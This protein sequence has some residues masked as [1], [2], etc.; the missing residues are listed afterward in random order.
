MKESISISFLSILIL[1]KKN[2]EKIII[3]LIFMLNFKNI[4]TIQNFKAIYNFNNEYY[5]IKAKSIDYYRYEKGNNFLVK[6]SEYSF[7][8]DQEI[9]T[10]EESEMISFGLFRDSGD[11]AKLIV[12]K[13]FVYA[14]LN[15]LCVCNTTL[16]EIE[17]FK[18]EIYGIK[19]ESQFHFCFYIIGIINSSKQFCLY[20]YKNP[21]YDC[22][23]TCVDYYCLNDIGSDNFSCELMKSSWNEDI[24]TCFYQ[25]IDSTQII[26]HNFNIN[27]NNYKISGVELPQDLGASYAECRCVLEIR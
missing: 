9:K 7:N 12:V 6:D 5:I 24:L 16:S 20:L 18:P 19:C 21:S 17:G 11:V 3:F 1:S 27:L 13:H 22:A 10:I 26:A 23:S 8:T 15:N 14:F 2:F 25:D 4:N